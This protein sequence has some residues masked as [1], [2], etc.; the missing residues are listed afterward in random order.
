MGHLLSSF[1]TDCELLLLLLFF[2]FLEGF[3]WKRE[4][5]YQY[6][7]NF[8]LSKQKIQRREKMEKNFFLQMASA[9]RG[10]YC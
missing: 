9:W 10:M 5:M 6:V 7:W 4:Q 8:S 3:S 2:L 1:R